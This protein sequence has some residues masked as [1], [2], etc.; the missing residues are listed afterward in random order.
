MVRQAIAAG[1][2]AVLTLAA[3]LPED[4]EKPEDL[5]GEARVNA[6]RAA[7]EADGGRFGRAGK[8]AFVCY[9]VPRDAGKYC[10]VAGDCSTYCL[11]RSNTCAPVEPLLGCN[12]IR[13]ASGE[14]TTRCTAFD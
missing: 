1:L 9:T 10:K 2:I 13:T 6:T 8:E 11:S 4:R 3:C 7:C 5:I 12:E 14:S